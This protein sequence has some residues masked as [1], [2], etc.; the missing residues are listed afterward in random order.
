MTRV[1]DDAAIVAKWSEDDIFDGVC[2][3]MSIRL[4][5]SHE[6]HHFFDRED[7]RGVCTVYRMNIQYIFYLGRE[8]A[9]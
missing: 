4:Q 8:V 3:F 7:A 2:V 1:D 6:R 5:R 9:G